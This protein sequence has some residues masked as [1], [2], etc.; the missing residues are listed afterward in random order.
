MMPVLITRDLLG[1]T[2]SLF[3][4]TLRLTDIDKADR[5]FWQF[6]IIK[7]KSSNHLF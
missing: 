4:L 6:P 7:I 2:D 1:F 3:W 5:F